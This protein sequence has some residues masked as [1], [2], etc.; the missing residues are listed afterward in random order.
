MQNLCSSFSFLVFNECSDSTNRLCRTR[1]PAEHVSWAALT[2]TRSQRVT[3]SKLQRHSSVHHQ[4]TWSCERLDIAAGSSAVAWK[5]NCAFLLKWRGIRMAE[6]WVT[7]PQ[8]CWDNVWSQ[9]WWS[10]VEGRKF[11]PGHNTE[12]P[13]LRFA[14]QWLHSWEV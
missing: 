5:V 11:V 9:E 3:C 1:C 8:S 12:E 7:E 10:P 13:Q 4:D 14:P 2:K 6:H